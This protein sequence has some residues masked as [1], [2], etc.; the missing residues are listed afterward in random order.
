MTRA[1]LVIVGLMLVIAFIIMQVGNNGVGNGI[2]TFAD[3]ITEK[4]A[5]V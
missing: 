4:A 2:D 3:A 1:A 5:T